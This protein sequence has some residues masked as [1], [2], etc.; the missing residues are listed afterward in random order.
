MHSIIFT[1]SLL[2]AKLVLEVKR[3]QEQTGQQPR[4]EMGSK[5]QQVSW[6]EDKSSGAPLKVPWTGPITF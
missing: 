3:G 5:G 2:C 1:E 4:G 6:N